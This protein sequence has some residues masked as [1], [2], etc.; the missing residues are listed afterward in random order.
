MTAPVSA[1]K[2]KKSTDRKWGKK[3]RKATYRE[4]K[5]NN[6]ASVRMNADT[7]DIRNW[8][9]MIESEL[10]E[11]NAGKKGR[12]YLYCDSMMVWIMTFMSYNCLTLRKA[13]GIAQGIMKTLGKTFPHYSTVCR[14]MRQIV[15]AECTFYGEGKIIA[16]YVR[17]YTTS[18]KR[19]V[20]VDSTG[21]TLNDSSLYREGKWGVSEGHRGW[22]K[23]HAL[24][25]VDTNEVLAFVL[26]YDDVG[27]SPQ[28]RPLVRM[29]LE[30]G[31]RIKTLYADSAY[32]SSESWVFLNSK[33]IEFNVRFKSN[34]VAHSNGCMD[35]G[36]SAK[37]WVE[38]GPDIWSRIKKYGL[39]WKIESAFS[40]FKRIIGE[41]VRSRTRKG[42]AV[43]ITA[44][45]IVYN[46]HKRIRA[47]LISINE[48]NVL[49]AE[50]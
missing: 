43:T 21:L 3:P 33:N 32:E 48:R 8:I 41:Y 35:R 26:T 39:R 4:T 36:E 23:L 15:S 31:H 38:Q 44:S 18:R 1:G 5:A 11:M 45:V 29:V 28:L 42:R 46:K 27:D 47:D 13:A 19:T 49:T 40:D 24:T 7:F 37:I 25:D 16:T 9:G 14:R 6:E 30:K 10:S 12:P 34:T 2:N 50:D 20:A 17:P 22:L